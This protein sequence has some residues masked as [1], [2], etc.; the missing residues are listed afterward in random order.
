MRV[1]SGDGIGEI[2]Y[3][4]VRD[5]TEHG[6]KINVRGQDCLEL[7]GLVV[8]EYHKPGACW[9][10]IPNRKW[11]VF[12]ALAEIPWILS[13]NGNVG[14]ISY[15]GSNMKSFQD[16]DNPE[17][18]GAYGLRLRKWPLYERS[19]REIEF[20]QISEVVRKLRV[21]PT[22]R[23][24][25]I[26]LWDPAR[27]NQP[28]KDIPCNNMVNYT[29]RDGVLHQT[30]NIR[31]N[32]LVWGTPY[33]AVQFTHL[34]VFVAGLLGVRMG[35]FTYVIHNL[36]Y[37][38]DLYKPTLANLIEQAYTDDKLRADSISSFD[39]FTGSDLRF[40][41]QDIEISLMEHVPVGCFDIPCRAIGQGYAKEIAD[42][43][44]LFIKVKSGFNLNTQSMEYLSELKQP[45]R[46]LM[47][48]FWEDS[49]KP[50]AKQVVEFL[51][52]N[53]DVAA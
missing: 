42:A 53:N 30:V 9:M 14:W 36:H 50:G 32:D 16:G 13:G 19:D 20:D 27:D 49:N 18:H 25:V 2:Y 31:S 8:L 44:K 43:L 29:L 22:T 15:F 48:D 3:D 24:A 17:F 21:D 39:I 1:Y 10:R 37:Y 41:K 35:L 11:N 51:R 28:S 7:P 47:A 6:R 5:V 23:Q 52:R 33:N 26:A 4:L 46:D 34:H 45:L 40:L 12:L 38:L